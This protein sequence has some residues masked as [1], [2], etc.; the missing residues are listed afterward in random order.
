[1]PKVTR[2]RSKETLVEFGRLLLII[3]GTIALAGILVLIAAKYF[4]WLGNLPG[5]FE[6][7]GE[8]YRIYFP[9]ATMIL[10]SVLG[11]ILLNIVIR[12]FRR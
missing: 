12:I 7:E 6:I 8:T 2:W 3:G 5:D 9:L 11:T 10:V 4:P 1:M